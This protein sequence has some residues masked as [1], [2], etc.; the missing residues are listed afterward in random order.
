MDDSLKIK[1]DCNEIL[2]NSEKYSYLK[3]YDYNAKDIDRAN[4]FNVLFNDCSLLDFRKST[5]EIS[6][7]YQ[8][9][10][11]NIIKCEDELLRDKTLNILKNSYELLSLV[12]YVQPSQKYFKIK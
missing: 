5:R 3:D 2:F 6:Y 8:K 11:N 12:T 9:L 7:A 10:Y 4:S 1:N